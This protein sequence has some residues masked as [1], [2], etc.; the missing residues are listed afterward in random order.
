MGGSYYQ[1]CG[2]G[3]KKANEVS[4]LQGGR[5]KH[6][7]YYVV[8]NILIAGPNGL[9]NDRLDP[10]FPFFKK[11]FHTDTNQQKRLNR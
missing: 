11:S 6:Q 7:I 3:Q 10:E 8:T 2:L 9:H 5:D 4:S 1:L